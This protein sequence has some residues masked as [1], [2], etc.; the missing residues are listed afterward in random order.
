MKD[1]KCFI[2]PLLLILTVSFCFAG[3]S[4][5]DSLLKE[6]NLKMLEIPDSNL[7]INIQVLNTEVTQ[8]F[9]ESIMGENPSNFKGSNFPVDSASWYDAIYFCNLI[10]EQVGLEP[11]YAVNGKT[12]VTTWGYEPL[13]GKR[14]KGTISQ[15]I[16]LSGVRLPTIKEWM[17]SAY[18]GEEHNF[19]GSDAP[20]VVAWHFQNSNY[21]THE[22]AQK[23]PNKYGLY[24]MSGNLAEW[25]WEANDDNT[26]GRRRLVCGGCWAMYAS[27]MQLNKIYYYPTKSR[28]HII[29]FRFVRTV[30]R[31]NTKSA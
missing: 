1:K 9:F 28:E 22:G 30:K 21:T 18:G 2:I 5:L 27:D 3:A 11:I 8:F 12:D 13:R 15:D 29:G 31:N 4:E 23:K 26:D 20:D 25:V 16:E 19:S 10:S 14:I 6:Y 7:D 24:D 17:I